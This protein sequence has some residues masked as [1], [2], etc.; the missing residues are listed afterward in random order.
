MTTKETKMKAIQMLQQGH[1]YSSIYRATGITEKSVKRYST[2]VE[3]Y[4]E[5]SLDQSSNRYYQPAQKVG[6]VLAVKRGSSVADAAAELGATE[7]S[8]RQWIRI[9]D[10]AGAEGLKDRRIKS[11]KTSNVIIASPSKLPK[12]SSGITGQLLGFAFSK[13]AERNKEEEACYVL[14]TREL[15][16][17]LIYIYYNTDWDKIESEGYYDSYSLPEDIFTGEI[18]KEALYGHVGEYIYLSEYGDPWTD[19]MTAE[20]FPQGIVLEFID[21]ALNLFIDSLDDLLNSSYYD[22]ILYELHRAVKLM[23]NTGLTYDQIKAKYM[24]SFYDR[25]FVKNNYLL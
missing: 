3:K 22:E 17:R 6:A 10:E 5:S 16:D 1:S 7:H 20:S 11:A 25:L 19:V 4:G 21:D 23:C 24:E 2:L 8:V 9:Y 18:N 12:D 13:L 14:L 15:A